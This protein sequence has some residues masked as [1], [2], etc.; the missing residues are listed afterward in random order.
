MR[1]LT[2]DWAAGLPAIVTQ[3]A[4]LTLE[5]VFVSKS[6]QASPVLPPERLVTSHFQAT[7]R[8]PGAGSATAWAL[9]SFCPGWSSAPC[10]SLTNVKAGGLATLSVA[11]PIGAKIDIDRTV[12]SPTS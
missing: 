7:Q 8:S 5:F 4:K 10:S 9:R 2:P 12:R 3:I 11:P 1:G 6:A